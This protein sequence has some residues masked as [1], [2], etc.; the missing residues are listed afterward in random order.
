MHVYDAP[1]EL[2]DRALKL[3]LQPY[4]EVLKITRGRFPGCTHVETGVR[5]VRMHV[6]YP[7]PSF[8][9]FGRRLVCTFHVGQQ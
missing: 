2:P 4:G 7:I 9:G 5:Y 8:I 6:D 3:R 1:F